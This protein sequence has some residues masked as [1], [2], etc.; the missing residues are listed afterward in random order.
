MSRLRARRL[1]SMCVLFAAFAALVVPGIASAK[2]VV[3][4]TGKSKLQCSSEL[5][6]KGEGSSAQKPAQQNVW[7]PGFETS[8]N[9]AAC[10]GTQDGKAHPKVTYAPEGSGAGLKAFGAEGEAIFHGETVQYAGTDEAPNLVQKE[11]IEAHGPLIKQ[12]P[13]LATIPVT[14]FAVAII[15]HLPNGCMAESAVKGAE[16]RLVLQ[17]KALYQLWIGHI[18]TW[19]ELIA[20]EENESAGTKGNKDRILPAECLEDHITHVVRFDQSGTTHTFKKYLNLISEEKAP[21]ENFAKESV[22]NRNFDETSEGKENTSWPVGDEVVRPAK[23]GGGEEAALV[24]T[25]PSSVGYVNLA[26]ARA[27][28]VGGTLFV[29]PGGGAGKLTFWAEVQNSG[30]KTETEAKK[31]QK[32]ADPSSNGD[33]QGLADS[34]CEGEK[35]TNGEGT[36]FPPASVFDTWNN[37]T[38]NTKQKKYTLCGLTYDLE[39]SYENLFKEPPAVGQATTAEN[40]L[41]YVL[42]EEAEGGQKLIKANQDFFEIGSKLDA[43]AKE[44][45]AQVFEEE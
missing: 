3:P 35:F 43:E 44:G 39:V 18:S 2:K 38:S 21:F 14:Q 26:E 42:N 23:K 25:M 11:E 20:L 36:K 22:G 13:D 12:K 29:P 1:L 34:N 15:I 37:V 17:N 30:T 41:A 4:K 24:A 45:L 27:A 28:N 16:G 19:G 40:F 9:P 8:K 6:I 10:S 7:I 32:Y 31:A 33:I 5:A